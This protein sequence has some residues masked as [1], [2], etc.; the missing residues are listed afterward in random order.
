L[1]TCD[2]SIG[3]RYLELADGSQRAE[4]ERLWAQIRAEHG[5]CDASLRAVRGTDDET[6]SRSPCLDALGRMQ[7]ELLR[8]HRAGDPEAR[9]PLLGT[10]AGIAA[11]LRTT[12]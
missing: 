1:A 4:V 12:G 9:E 2:L 8:R 10:V 11:G 6:R 3:R 7:V 5:R